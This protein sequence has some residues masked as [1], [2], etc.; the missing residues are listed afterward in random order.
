MNFDGL[1]ALFAS[2][3]GALLI[4]GLRIVDVS[5]DTLRVLFA[6][7]GKRGI[8][9]VLGFVMATVWIVAV[10]NAIR[11][12]DSVWHILGYGGGYAA[13]TFVG[14]TIESALAYGV[15][16]VS[17]I[18]RHGGV[19]I[20]EA[21]RD[22][23]YGATEFT[24]HGREGTVELVTC[25]VHRSHLEEVFQLVH[26]WDEEAFVTVD[27]PKVLKGGLLATR[28]WPSPLGGLGRRSR[29]GRV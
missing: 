8:A 3:W 28:E 9:A 6:F 26:R 5:L 4:F 27:E 11:H 15:S 14:I 19:E 1:D 23:G 10:G 21:L 12:I 18:S 22:R 17:I 7:R 24:G 13:G 29:G 20:A 2:R 25:V 16:M